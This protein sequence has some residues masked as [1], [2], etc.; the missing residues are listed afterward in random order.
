MFLIELQYEH[1]PAGGGRNPPGDPHEGDRFSI[2]DIMA[3]THTPTHACV[4]VRVRV[5][6]CV[7]VCACVREPCPPQMWKFDQ[8]D[9]AVESHV[10]PVLR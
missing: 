3:C 1:Q 5:C 4:R 8:A 9:M 7:C 10:C 6:V 2:Y